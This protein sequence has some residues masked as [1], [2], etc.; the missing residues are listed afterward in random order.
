[1]GRGGG[2]SPSRT[3]DFDPGFATDLPLDQRH[4]LRF[5]V[6]SDNADTVTRSLVVE[7]PSSGRE[8]KLQLI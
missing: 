5:S 4:V 7:A 8:V 3:P 2:W 1:M 6:F